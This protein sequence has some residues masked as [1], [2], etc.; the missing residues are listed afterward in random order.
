MNFQWQGR[1]WTSPFPD[2]VRK[3]PLPDFE[4]ACIAPMA[5]DDKRAACR[6]IE[7]GAIP[8]T[9]NP[10]R[11]QLGNIFNATF[12]EI[13]DKNPRPPLSEIEKRLVRS[14]KNKERNMNVGACR[15]L[16]TFA[17][18]H[19]I[20]GYHKEFLPLQILDVRKSF[21]WS[22]YILVIDGTPSVIFL[23]PRRGKYKLS[24]QGMTFVFSAMNRQ[25]R[26]AHPDDFGD[27]NLGI[28]QLGEINKIERFAE[29]HFLKD[30]LYEDDLLYE[31]VLEAYIIWG[32]E[33]ERRIKERRA[34]PVPPFELT[35]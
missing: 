5:P 30:Q 28:I 11:R 8:D 18:Q 35:A 22:P 10:V 24:P 29:I 1:R 34:A 32:E 12:G 9:Y 27:V 31:M 17:E 26:L 25:I 33:L 14:C 20:M 19:V 3:F 21:Y 23:D 2:I 4:L 16:Y 6:E 13:I 7:V 15:A